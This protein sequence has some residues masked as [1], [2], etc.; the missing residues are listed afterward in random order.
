[1]NVIVSAQRFARVAELADAA[2][3]KSADESHVGSSPTLG[4]YLGGVAKWQ[5]RLFQVQVD[6]IREGSNPSAPTITRGVGR[7]DECARMEIVWAPKGVSG[8]RIPDSPP[9]S[10][11]ASFTSVT[12]IFWGVGRVVDCSRLE[13]DRT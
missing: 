7:V 6:G 11:V 3:S 5:T 10:F 12:F 8:V 1:M 2:D 13:S 4:T 9:E